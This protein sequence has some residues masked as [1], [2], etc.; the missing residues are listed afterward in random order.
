MRQYLDSEKNPIHI[1]QHVAVWDNFYGG[2]FR[3]EVIGFTPQKVRFKTVDVNNEHITTLKYPSDLM[4][5]K[6]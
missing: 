1:G 4:I 3:C 5:I 6:K 2:M